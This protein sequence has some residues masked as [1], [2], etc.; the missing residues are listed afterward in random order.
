LQ[1][2]RIK[3]IIYFVRKNIREKNHISVFFISDISVAGLHETKATEISSNNFTTDFVIF[4]LLSVIKI[5]ET[6]L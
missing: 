5:E 6:L 3:R 4:E 1:I 2:R